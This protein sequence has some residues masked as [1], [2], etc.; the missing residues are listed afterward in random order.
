VGIWLS[1]HREGKWSV[2]VAVANGAALPLPDRRL[3]PLLCSR[4]CLLRQKLSV[5]TVQF[6]SYRWVSVNEEAEVRNCSNFR[7]PHCATITAVTHIPCQK[8]PFQLRKLKLR[9]H[10]FNP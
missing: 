5:R 2:P 4:E 9:G 6:P 8:H 7:W 1:R 10:T 3:P